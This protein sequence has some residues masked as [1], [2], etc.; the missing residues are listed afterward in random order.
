MIRCA[1]IALFSLLQIPT[2]VE[3]GRRDIVS[4]P[5][6]V[7][8]LRVIDGDTFVAEAHMWPGQHIQVSVRLRGIDAP[9]MRSKCPAERNAARKARDALTS[10]LEAGEV[11]ISAISG[12]KYYGRVLADVRT[13]DGLDIG[14]RLLETRLVAAYGGGRRI[15]LYC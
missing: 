11:S 1:F 3:A 13:S 2:P 14:R 5:V 4:G 10:L 6:Q 15:S 8:V 7:R 12:G 9:E